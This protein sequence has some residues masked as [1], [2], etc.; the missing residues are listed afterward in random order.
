[1]RA[2]WG[3]AIALCVVVALPGIGLTQQSADP[4]ERWGA[5]N[6]AVVAADKAGN[7]RAAILSA[8]QALALARSEFGERDRR[9]L[10][11]LSNL[12]VVY[13]DNGRDVDA[14]PLAVQALRLSREV[15]GER[16][17]DTISCL[18]SLASVYDHEGRFPDAEPLA[19]QALQLR[20]EVDGERHPETIKAMNNLAFVYDNEGRYPE[21]E[22]LYAQALQ[23]GRE[24]LGELH[25]DVINTLNNLAS[26][27]AEEGHY[28]KAEKLFAKA[29]QLRREVLG[30]R[31]PDTI[32]SLNNLSS[33]YEDEGRYPEAEKLHARA[34]Q[35]RREVLGE[36]HPD[37]ISSTSNLGTDYDLEGRYGDAERLFTQALQLRRDVLGERN[38]E[39]VASLNNL[40][41]VYDHEGRYAEA[42]K[43]YAQA[44]EFKQ[45]AL[46]ERHPDTILGMNNLAGV[47]EDEERYTEAEPLYV[48]VLQLRR[49]ALGER[50]PDTISSLN[51]LATVYDDEGRYPEAEKLYA[52]ALQLG[53]EV[54]G[55]RH[56]D[57]ITT[58]DNLA[59][60]DS[61]EGHNADAE[62]LSAQALKLRQEVLGKRHPDTITSLNN[63]GGVYEHEGRYTEA[64]GF[65]SEALQLSLEAI[66]P[67]SPT[68]IAI[69]ENHV[70]ALARLGRV[71]DALAQLRSLAPHRLSRL[72]RELFGTAA[73]NVQHLL[74]GQETAFQDLV[75]SVAL[76]EKTP[77]T[78][79]LAGDVMLRWKR[80]IAAEDA[81][82]ARFARI[83]SDPAVRSI[84]THVLLLRRQL[85]AQAH[86]GVVD[87]AR[88]TLAELEAQENELGR[89]SRG[90]GDRLRVAN[91][92][93]SDVQNAMAPGDV[94]LEFRHYHP[95]LATSKGVGDRWALLVVRGREADPQL[96][97]AGTVD[98][99][100]AARATL[101]SEGPGKDGGAA[102]SVLFRQLF[103]DVSDEVL[104]AKRVWIASDGSLA[105]VPFVRLLLP[106]GRLW[107][108]AQELH[109]IETGRELLP[110][111]A[112]PK[113]SSGLIAFGGI[114]FGAAPGAAATTVVATLSE[115]PIVTATLQV[116][117][118]TQRAASDTLRGA[119]G[120]FPPLPETAEEVEYISGY[121]SY[122]RPDEV[123]PRVKEGSEASAPALRSLL[124]GD[125][126]PRV[127]HFATHGFFLPDASPID[128]PLLKAGVAL[129]G[130]NAGVDPATGED[131]ILYA[132]EARGLDL[133]GTELVALS[134]C[135]TA[136]GRIDYSEGIEGLVQAFHTAGARW[137]LVSLRK[138]GDHAAKEFM[139]DFYDIWLA[140]PRSDP[141]AALRAVQ[142]SWATS[143]DPAHADPA[144]WDPWLLVGR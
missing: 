143:Q 31:H 20:R 103:G 56:P 69:Q 15:L 130:A 115:A 133:E 7:Y 94:L 55:N 58:L 134:G 87:A 101:L 48:Q 144:N 18:T 125:A 81:F 110:R 5:L 42:E 88:K 74:L 111:E 97:D 71:T 132:I 72:G 73:A 10:T 2:S 4:A 138:V 118:K 64:E 16:D 65:Y 3:L 68:A 121:Y 84:A 139:I 123:A 105:L 107:G 135:K 26:I 126:A 57:V 131:G 24:V 102:A 79:A 50:H 93:L 128:R 109:F 40:A 1:M 70:R 100:N 32:V 136:E 91:A 137:V 49:V 116:D 85:A 95:L 36:R 86:S 114:D 99:S 27:Y 8:E 12:A 96:F 11:S 14:E 19:V 62:K 46:G 9:T 106:D 43:L 127:L 37:T 92:T 122:R 23:R 66:K 104:S 119:M 51:N 60:V 76:S 21:A 120:S 52:Q 82:I 30:A 63:L 117:P 39:T 41:A 112:E 6:R 34:L 80:V 140:Q 25:P 108:A 61:E 35:L 124:A 75:L 90:I 33:V 44:L 89:R 38:P 47:Y 141:A 59:Y 28:A 113:T 54:L 83:D 17:P 78:A 45:A 22:K 29:L 13:N 77:A 53:R 98:D 129:A 142:R 67:D